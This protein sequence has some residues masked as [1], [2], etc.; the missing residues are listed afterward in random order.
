MNYCS[1]L[2]AIGQFCPSLGHASNFEDTCLPT[3]TVWI[4]QIIQLPVSRVYLQIFQI[5]KCEFRQLHAPASMNLHY[6][7][8]AQLDFCSTFLRN[9]SNFISI[10]ICEFLCIVIDSQLHRLSYYNYIGCQTVHA[11]IFCQFFAWP[12]FWHQDRCLDSVSDA[13]IDPVFGVTGMLPTL[14]QN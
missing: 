1:H 9:Y 11:C 12:N 10:Y 7:L 8:S 2:K 14:L 5:C 3:W 4:L 13:T 6:R